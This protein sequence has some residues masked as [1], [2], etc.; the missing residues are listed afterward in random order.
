MKWQKALDRW[1]AQLPSIR[2]AVKRHHNKWHAFRS[3]LATCLDEWQGRIDLGYFDTSRE[4]KA[5]CENHAGIELE[6]KLK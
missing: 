4:G 5:A 2:Y 6:E 3:P 1:V